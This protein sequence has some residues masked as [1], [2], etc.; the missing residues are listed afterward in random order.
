[1]TWAAEQILLT[2]VDDALEAVESGAVDHL[3]DLQEEERR[4]RIREG[5]IAEGIVD[6]LRLFREDGHL[7]KLEPVL[8]ES[9]DN[10]LRRYAAAGKLADAANQEWMASL[11]TAITG[12]GA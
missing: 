1:M 6:K 5:V 4:T 11:H 7:D 9:I 12:S 8:L 2:L 3:M 10:D